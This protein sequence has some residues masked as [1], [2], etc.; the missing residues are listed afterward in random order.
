M[1]EP[2]VIKIT[3][4][5][6]FDAAT[7]MTETRNDFEKE[8]RIYSITV[9]GPVG[10]LPADFFGLISKSAPKLVGI[11]NDSWNPLNLAGVRTEGVSTNLRGVVTLRPS[12]QHIALNGDDQLIVQTRNGGRS[13]L[14]LTVN[15]LSER[16]HV[17]LALRDGRAPALRAFRLRRTDGA[18]WTGAV[19]DLP[20]TVNFTY[21]A[22]TGILQGD[23]TLQGPLTLNSLCHTPTITSCYAIVRYSGPPGVSEVYVQDGEQ[24]RVIN[25]ESGLP[26]MA[27][28]RVIYLTRDDRLL[29]KTPAPAAGKQVHVDVQVVEVNPREPFLGRFDYGK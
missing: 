18:G 7:P 10:I 20:I 24:N 21:N 25:L 6:D 14:Y 11:S 13:A 12:V 4:E 2:Y 5:A 17:D 1:A 16:D 27:W 15:A 26:E 28:S 3:S 19:T 9:Q 23:T 22:S 8:G 29:F